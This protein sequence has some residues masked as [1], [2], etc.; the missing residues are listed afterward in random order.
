[1]EHLFSLKDVSGTYCE[2][3]GESVNLKMKGFVHIYL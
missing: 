3:T 1:M 2:C